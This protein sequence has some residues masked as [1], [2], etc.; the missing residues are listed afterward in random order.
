MV[1]AYGLFIFFDGPNIGSGTDRSAFR[2]SSIEAKYQVDM[3]AAGLDPDEYAYLGD[4]IYENHPPS[5]LAL[6]KNPPVA[7]NPA[8]HFESIEST[9]RTSAEWGNSKLTEN[10]KALTF[11]YKNKIQMSA[12]GRDV[13][14]AALLTNCLVLLHGSQT[15]EFFADP[16]NACSLQMPSL[17]AY[18]V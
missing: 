13:I 3:N 18:F 4:K 15:R 17:Q 10:W 8:E 14:V 9:C 7:P 2:D 11:E 12:V 6:L 1:N 5:W 16:L